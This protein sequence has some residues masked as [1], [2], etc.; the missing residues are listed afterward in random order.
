MPNIF[1][2]GSYTRSVREK[3]MI[4]GSGGR[5]CAFAVR[6]AED[7]SVYAMMGHEEPHDKA[8]RGAFWRQV[9]NW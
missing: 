7:A 9:G 2:K 3:F 5:E 6:L 1:S 8:V 4:V